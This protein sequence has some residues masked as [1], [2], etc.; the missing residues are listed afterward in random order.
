MDQRKL[1]KLGNSSFAIA[2]PKQWVDKAGLKKGD[3]IFITPNSNG[4]LIIQPQYIKS[5]SDEEMILNL[6]GKGERDIYREIIAAYING[7]DL[8]KIK[9]NKKDLKCA[10]EALKGLFGVEIIDTKKDAI[11]SKGIIDIHSLSID[12]ITRRIDNSVRDIIE[13][14]E[15]LIKKGHLSS[16]EYDEIVNAKKDVNRSYFL[17]C[18]IM[19]QGIDNPSILNTLKINSS[20]LVY[21]WSVGLHIKRIGDNLKE[22][23]RILSKTKLNETESELMLSLLQKTK[24]NFITSLTTYHLKDKEQSSTIAR[25]KE[26]I[27][28]LC[29]RTSE[30]SI[31]RELC[32][33]FIKIQ[34]DTHNIA[35]YV[36]DFIK[37]DSKEK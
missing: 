13:E 24:E 17:L 21:S 26:E 5:N 36:M 11:T 32:N 27:H 15:P 31:T 18:R 20:T 34:H 19:V 2:L 6:E 16:K 22:I 4:E 30:R 33:I 28:N 3:N 37:E 23:A 10:K 12:S 25:T 35:R 9:V 14:L 1:I 8:I 7:M 29:S